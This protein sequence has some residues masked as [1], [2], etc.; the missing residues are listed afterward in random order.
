MRC[1]LFPASEDLGRAIEFL[2]PLDAKLFG[3]QT[4]AVDFEAAVRLDKS[5]FRI[6]DYAKIVGMRT[7]RE[8]RYELD[9]GR[10]V[11]QQNRCVSRLFKNYAGV[12]VTIKN[13]KKTI[14]NLGF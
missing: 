12:S 8:S 9:D 4:D 2:D 11:R 1:L 10:R 14:T 3:R 13:K 7:R 6:T 5:V